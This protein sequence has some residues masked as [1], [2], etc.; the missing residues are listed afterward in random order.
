MKKN[1]HWL[2][3]IE[4][5]SRNSVEGLRYKTNMHHWGEESYS[6]YQFFYELVANADDEGATAAQLII[7]NNKVIF[8]HNGNEFTKEDVEDITSYLKKK[9]YRKLDKIG[10]DMEEQFKSVTGVKVQN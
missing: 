8:Q 6:P 1:A 3:D 7:D 4:H 10:N 5:K 9:K 2:D